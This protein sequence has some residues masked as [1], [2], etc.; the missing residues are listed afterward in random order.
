MTLVDVKFV[1]AFLTQGFEELLV[2]LLGVNLPCSVEVHVFKRVWVLLDQ[3]SWKLRWLRE[4][5]HN[6][7][8]NGAFLHLFIATEGFTV[9]CAMSYKVL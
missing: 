7:K 1:N 3:S 5:Q 2:V 9:L 4:A 6:V 8:K